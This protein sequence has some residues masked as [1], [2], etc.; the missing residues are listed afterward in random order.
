MRKL[1]SNFEEIQ[2]SP[3]ASRAEAQYGLPGRVI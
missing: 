3:V 2:S 1:I